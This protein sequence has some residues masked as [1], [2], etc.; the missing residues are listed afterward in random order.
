MPSEI[1]TSINLP[2]VSGSGMA[3]YGRKPVAEMIELL[4]AS[5]RDQIAQAN[6]ILEAQDTDFR[7]CTFRGIYV[8]RDKVILQEGRSNP[9]KAEST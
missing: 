5:A 9:R 8:Q 7:V 6:A 1:M 3:D 2:G 4:R